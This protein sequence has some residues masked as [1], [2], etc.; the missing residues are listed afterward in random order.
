[1]NG[2]ISVESEP[3]KGSMFTVR[4]PQIATG[5]GVVGK[6][7]S[8]NLQQLRWGNISRIKKT[9]I[10]YEPMP[11]GNILIVDDIESNLYVAQ[12]LTA[13][14]KLSVDTATSGLEAIEKIKKGNV[15]DLIFMDHM[16]P[17]MDGIEATKIIRS[18]NYIQPIV[19]L[20]ANAIAGQ[21]EMFL[22]NGFDDYLSKPIDT[23][24]L[25][26][27]LNKL[28]R[29]KQPPEVIEAVKMAAANIATTQHETGIKNSK[30]AS[31]ILS[32]PRLL[33][34]FIRD[35]EK[36][37][38]KLD[39]ISKNSFRRDDDVQM[40]II[41]V[42]GMKSAL[43]SAGEIE[44]SAFALKLEKAGERKDTAEMLS[45][46]PEFLYGLR[47]LIRRI[48]PKEEE[49]QDVVEDRMLLCDNLLVIEAACEAYKRRVAKNALVELKQ[50]KWLPTTQD[51]LETL[52]GHI[53]HGEF[54]KAAEIAK[55]NFRILQRS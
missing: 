34:I 18:M 51:M 38:L 12:G 24:R 8:E 7:L 44:L 17:E 45:E 25:D 30:N 4:L 54:E 1:M 50:K 20:T 37:I 32:N 15:Y 35:V 28:I 36:A 9:K 26:L 5:S 43:A 13:P 3:G 39:E 19:A 29:D 23:H 22:A 10:S 46:T 33:K 16:M 53:L 31:Q 42:H 11:Y 47:E 14:Y 27:V 21:T 2:K 41:T 49:V 55:N 6:E 52:T 40:F 48:M